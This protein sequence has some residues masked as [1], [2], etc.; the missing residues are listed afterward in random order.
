LTVRS[1]AS[2][3]AAKG[4]DGFGGLVRQARA[5]LTVLVPEL[6]PTPA[7][8]IAANEFSSGSVLAG[9]NSREWLQEATTG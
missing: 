7:P 5:P 2:A 6:K 3:E 1:R 8:A 4:K 9:V